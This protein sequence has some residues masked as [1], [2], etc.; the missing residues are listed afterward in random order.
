MPTQGIYNFDPGAY[1]GVYRPGH[2]LVRR[3]T[4]VRLVLA[5][6]VRRLIT[7]VGGR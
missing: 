1:F 7:M 2:V 4:A 5:F 6:L 3:M